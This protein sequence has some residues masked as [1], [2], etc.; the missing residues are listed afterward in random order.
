M[1][2][3]QNEFLR[4]RKD[5]LG[6]QRHRRVKLEKFK[7]TMDAVSLDSLQVQTTFPSAGST[8]CEDATD[9]QCI[10]QGDEWQNQSLQ[11]NMAQLDFTDKIDQFSFYK[12][13]T[14]GTKSCPNSHS[15][16]FDTSQA[17]LWTQT[18]TNQRMPLNPK[19]LDISPKS[20]SNNVTFGHDDFYGH[21]E[22]LNPQDVH[23]TGRRTIFEDLSIA[24]D[25][26]PGI[27]HHSLSND[28]T[29]YMGCAE[30]IGQHLVSMTNFL[31]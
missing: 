30:K 6:L 4:A 23:G 17:N 24:T 27:N 3:V 22:M 15:S 10:K 2:D 13:P 8:T 28:H 21:G 16:R 18:F 7:D 11:C 5:F 14:L 26:I 20:T 1:G 12:A 31:S 19:E 25:D 9:Q 29:E